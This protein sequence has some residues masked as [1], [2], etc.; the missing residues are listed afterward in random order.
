[1]GNDETMTLETFL[2]AWEETD[3]KNK[4]AFLHLKAFLEKKEGVVFEFIPRPG[5]TYSLRASH[6]NQKEKSLFAMLDVIED[7]PR[8]LSVCF[9]GA[10]ITDP[11]EEGDFVPEG[12]LGEDA[13]CFDIDAWEDRLVSYVESRLTEAWKSAKEEN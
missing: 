8:W 12:L 10:M 1:M 7:S 4:A 5:L 9:Y 13:I 2:D 3:E 11:D 6:P